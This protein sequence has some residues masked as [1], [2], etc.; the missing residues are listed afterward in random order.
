MTSHNPDALSS[1]RAERLLL[2]LERKPERSLRVYGVEPVLLHPIHYCFKCMAA[3][4]KRIKPWPSSSSRASPSPLPLIYRSLS[5]LTVIHRSK[6]PITL[7]SSLTPSSGTNSSYGISEKTS[8]HSPRVPKK[9]S[10]ISSGP[11]TTWSR[12][13]VRMR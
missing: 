4:E 6:C 3:H 10:T 2:T 8:P 7:E 9:P 5:R 1:T 13:G 12:E 11:N